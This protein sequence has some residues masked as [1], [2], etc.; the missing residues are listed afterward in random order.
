MHLCRHQHLEHAHE[1]IDASPNH[2]GFLVAALCAVRAKAKT[3]WACC[4]PSPAHS[5]Q[6]CHA[7][8]AVELAWR[9]PSTPLPFESLS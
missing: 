1:T 9:G 2:V 7:H 4:N 8:G 5:T 3:R 6:R